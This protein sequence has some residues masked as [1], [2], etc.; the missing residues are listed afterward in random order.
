[1]TTDHDVQKLLTHIT[2]QFGTDPE[3]WFLPDGYQSVALAVLDAIYS[4]GNRYAGVMNVV[5]GYRRLRADEGADPEADTVTDLVDAFR[6]WGG[7]DE[8]VLKTNNRWRTSSQLHA[9]YKAY[10]ALEAAKVLAR[11]SIETVSDVAGRLDSRASRE[12]SDIA[13]QWLAI[14]GQSSA[15]T[16]S[17]F[18]MLV[19]IPGVKADRMIVRFVTQVLGRPR[20]VSRKEAS[21]LVEEVADIMGVNCI[22]LDHTIWR[23]QSGRPYLQPTVIPDETTEP[24]ALG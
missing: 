3:R 9:P 11:H 15:L 16:W 18:L 17:Y 19:G 14:T 10:A 23:Y 24:P 6:R 8:F 22:Y 5:N 12:H 1:M 13:R 2:A 4:T 20:E 21:R 7:V